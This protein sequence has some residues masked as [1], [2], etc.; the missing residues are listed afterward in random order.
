[1]NLLIKAIDIVN[2]TIN[3]AF[4]IFSAHLFLDLF[5]EGKKWK[6]SYFVSILVICCWQIMVA[7]AVIKLQVTI[8]L[9]I[10]AISIFAIQRY[11]GNFFV[12][13][14][15]AVLYTTIW[16]LIE[17]LIGYIFLILGINISSHMFTGSV[18]SKS[19]TILLI[20]LFRHLKSLT[21]I[22]EYTKK[23]S[24]V[25]TVT[26]V[27]SLILMALVFSR[28]LN[29]NGLNQSELNL[30]F[31]M[32]GILIFTNIIVL[33]TY[34]LLINEFEIKE[35]NM[36]FAQQVDL[37][38]EHT[39]EI[40][41]LLNNARKVN[42]NVK[43]Q[44]VTL[45]AYLEASCIAE[46]KDYLDEAIN[47]GWN[48]SRV[49]NTGNMAID[50]IINSKYLKMQEENIVFGLDINI[51][52]AIPFSGI[53]LSILIG[54]ILDNSIE[55]NTKVHNLD[56]YIQLYITYE[57]NYLIL[58]CVNVYEGN[59][60]INPKGDINTLKQNKDMHGFGIAS[61]KSIC[62]KYNG[63]VNIEYSNNKF[64]IKCLLFI[65]K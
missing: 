22:T 47:E 31:L 26:P 55:A 1:M 34:Q 11:Y 2:I 9:S 18:I 25:I 13:I 16:I 62:E 28:N 43:H 44:M 20:W 48:S 17:F 10:I 57:N 64:V 58:S 5:F 52:S 12:K 3:M 35:Q 65:Q 59:I 53:D 42:H 39:D 46:A 45:R 6:T 54:N 40:E 33:K 61:I 29:Y 63:N 51:P 24:W 21:R 14:S 30:S 36:Q 50:A 15:F 8:F 49:C 60:A 56:R 23:Y 37:T 7:M 32:V 38:K 4:S 41:L 27:I 19:L